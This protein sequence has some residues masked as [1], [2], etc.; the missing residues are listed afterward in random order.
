MC[1]VLLKSKTGIRTRPIRQKAN[2]GKFR[3]SPET[4]SQSSSA[5]SSQPSSSHA[6]SSTAPTT[7][8]TTSTTKRAMDTT[9]ETRQSVLSILGRV[10][11]GARPS[12]PGGGAHFLSALNPGDGN[13]GAMSDNEGTRLG[14]S[15]NHPLPPTPNE[16]GQMPQSAG[17]GAAS[18][19][20]RR[21]TATSNNNPLPP[22]PPPPSAS[23]NTTSGGFGGI[24]RRRRST[25]DTPGVPPAHL[26]AVGLPPQLAAPTPSRR[27]VTQTT[28]QPT[29]TPAAAPE[30]SRPQG[31]FTRTASTPNPAGSS[32]PQ[33]I[34]LVPHLDT[35]RSLH[36]EA[37]TRDVK[38]G[39][40]ALRIGRFTDR[41]NQGINHNLGNKLAFKS[42]VVSRGHA[43]VWLSEGKVYLFISLL[44]SHA[45]VT[46]FSSGS[47]TRRHRL[48]RFL[49]TS[50]YQ[51]LEQRVHRMF[52][53]MAMSFNSGS[54]SRYDSLYSHTPRHLRLR[55]FV[56]G[57]TEDIYKCVKI[58]IEIGREWQRSNNAFK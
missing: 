27:T 58:R 43:E 8:P 4:T 2:S 15:T 56:Q 41:S 29:L 30:P 18:L 55:L 44:V 49:I 47:K 50:D 46:L 10:G 6:T 5:P 25:T 22:P 24:L 42:K 52:S 51:L 3:S 39:D 35:N 48:A 1:A 11:R 57:G 13:R 17:A 16:F 14:S 20:H 26:I 21:R 32:H 12:D 7:H 38:P 33:R 28:A 31:S 37:F 36:F 54:I 23:N 9:G 34:R 40:S 53:K 45:D 19:G